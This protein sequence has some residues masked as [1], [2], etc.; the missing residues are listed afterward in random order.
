MIVYDKHSI[1][2]YGGKNKLCKIVLEQLNLSVK[3]KLSFSP[4]NIHKNKFLLLTKSNTQN[5]QALGGKELNL[6]VISVFCKALFIVTPKSQAY[7]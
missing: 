6:F 5:H 4:Q 7:N 3:D 1:S 2:R